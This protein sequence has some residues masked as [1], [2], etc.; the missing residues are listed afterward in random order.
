MLC[1]IVSSVWG[2]LQLGGTGTC[3]ALPV[4][5][6]LPYPATQ[7]RAHNSKLYKYTVSAVSYRRTKSSV[8]RKHTPIP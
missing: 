8:R 6:S 5:A 4:P 3:L 1:L 2:P 7:V